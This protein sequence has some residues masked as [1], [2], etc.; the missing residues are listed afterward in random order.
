MDTIDTPVQLNYNNGNNFPPNFV[1]IAYVIL[2][3]SI[4]LIVTGTFLL[5]GI[6]LLLGLLVVTNRHIVEIDE[7]KNTVHDYS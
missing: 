7:E 2:A 1:L 3:A 4:L 6:A 5:G